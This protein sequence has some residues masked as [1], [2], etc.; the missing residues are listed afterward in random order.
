MAG[1]IRKGPE[2]IQRVKIYDKEERRDESEF[3][4]DWFSYFF[5]LFILRQGLI[6][7]PR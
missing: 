7:L 4:F 3:D 1:S 2:E 6:Q 5:S